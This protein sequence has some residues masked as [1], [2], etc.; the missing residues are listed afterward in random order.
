MMRGKK[1]K[2]KLDGSGFL[3]KGTFSTYR[4]VA[5][6]QDGTIREKRPLT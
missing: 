6:L 5:C 2:V 3:F 4:L 1:K